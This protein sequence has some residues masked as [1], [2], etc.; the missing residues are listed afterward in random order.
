[1]FSD[2]EIDMY[3]EE[4]NKINLLTEFAD[5]MGFKRIGIGILDKDKEIAYYTTQIVDGRISQVL[6]TKSK[7][8]FTAKIQAKH[9]KEMIDDKSWIL[10]NP[11][12]AAVK[13]SSKIRLPFIVKARLMKEYLSIKAKECL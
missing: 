6:K 7:T 4:F 2:E 3:I 12:K 1:M 11:K 9:L 5:K 8:E 10:E 13:Y